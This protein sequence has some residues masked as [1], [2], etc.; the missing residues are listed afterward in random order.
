VTHPVNDHGLSHVYFKMSDKP[1]IS[2]YHAARSGAAFLPQTES[3]FLLLEGQDRLAFLQRMTTNDVARLSPTHSIL[4]VLVNAAARILDVLRLVH[5]SQD[6]LGVITLSGHAANTAR[7][8]KGRIFFMDKVLLQDA[9]LAYAQVDLD[10]PDAGHILRQLGCQEPPEE[11]ECN[12]FQAGGLPV[13]VIGQNGFSAVGYRLLYPAELK[14]TLWAALSASGA[15][16][17]SAAEYEILRVEAGFPAAG[18]ELTEEF[19]P[20]ETGLAP[21]I[22]SDKGCYT[23]QEV[24][25]RQITYDKV[26]Q[27]LAGLRLHAPVTPGQRIWVEG[28]PVGIVTS[29]VDSPLHGPIALAII[30]R[31]SHTPGTDVII[32][33]EGNAVGISAKV[34]ELPFT[35]QNP[36]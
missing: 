1:E 9:S 33:G 23:G 13:R 34:V 21:A 22:S 28:R 8:L 2:A 35:H 7:F 36:S 18:H 20:L 3:G 27:S 31:P 5:I 24:I 12:L 30:K 25:A 26:T 10:G 16:Q 4:T 15:R 11:G 32:G 6:A 14:D 29:A 17:L 19:T